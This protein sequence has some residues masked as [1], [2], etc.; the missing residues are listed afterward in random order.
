MK[1]EYHEEFSIS[2]IASLQPGTI[3]RRMGDGKDQ[4]GRFVKPSD[5]GQA[6][7]VLE[8]IDLSQNEFLSEGGIVRPGPS[9][10]LLKHKFNFETSEKAE[11]ALQVVKNWPLYRDRED[12]QGAIIDFV[13]TAFSPEQILELKKSD[14][15]KPLFVTIQHRFSIGRHQPKVD[16]EKVRWQSFQ[17]AL[18]SLY[19]GKH[20][21]YVAFVPTDQ[22]HDPKFFSIGTKPHVET[23]KQLER[24]EFYFKPT[25]GG[26]IKVVSAT[27]EKP[28]RFIVDAGSNEYG[29]GVK[30]S[31]STAEVICD[32][33]EDAHP[34]A[35]YTPVKGRDAYGIQQ[36]F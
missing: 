30:S 24:E 28:K 31:I 15:L 27:N 4:Q 25:N 33:L 1:K 32:A 7:V 35:E 29:A 2:D 19:D 26:H 10:T 11:A 20:L 3:V 9:D 14:D 16:W 22:N 34:G 18:D 36:S 23:V 5:D 21:T 12:L 13:K 8:V 17:D 6:M